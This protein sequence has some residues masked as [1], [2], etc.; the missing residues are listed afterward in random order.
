MS[1]NRLDNIMNLADESI[2]SFIDISVDALAES[3]IKFFK[4]GKA[5]YKIA[6]DC[7]KTPILVRDSGLKF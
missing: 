1:N 7:P 4:L 6:P 5:I 3:D 2:D